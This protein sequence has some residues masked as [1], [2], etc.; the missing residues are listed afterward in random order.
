M[1]AACKLTM[2]STLDAGLPQLSLLVPLLAL[3]LSH[4]C[5]PCLAS[6]RRGF[7]PQR[8]SEPLTRGARRAL[9]EELLAVVSPLK[10]EENESSRGVKPKSSLEGSHAQLQRSASRGSRSPTRFAHIAG[11]SFLLSKPAAGWGGCVGKDWF[12]GLREHP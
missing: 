2:A 11:P 4:D 10:A 12:V 7:S 3:I 9:G 6:P 5:L 8:S 1:A